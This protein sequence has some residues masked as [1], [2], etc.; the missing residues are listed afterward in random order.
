MCPFEK[1]ARPPF[2]SKT[3]NGINEHHEGTLFVQI[4]QNTLKTCHISKRQKDRLYMTNSQVKTKAV[5]G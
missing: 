5:L 2:C 4:Q 1:H 3:T